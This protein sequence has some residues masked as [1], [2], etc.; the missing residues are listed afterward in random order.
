MIIRWISNNPLVIIMMAVIGP[1]ELSS[2][3]TMYTITIWML[4]HCQYNNT[5]GSKILLMTIRDD[6]EVA[7]IR[8]WEFNIHWIISLI[9]L[10]DLYQ[11]LNSLYNLKICRVLWSP[12]THQILLCLH[13]LFWLH[14]KLI[15]CMLCTHSHAVHNNFHTLGYVTYKMLWIS[16]SWG[17][18]TF[19][20]PAV[21][22]YIPVPWNCL[23]SILFWMKMCISIIW[24]SA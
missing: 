18:F 24:I 8:V 3:M 10:L 15:S 13:N 4:Y 17:V 22:S 9:L 5:L 16:V 14:V 2:I 12:I 19:I 1:A 11:K 21:L 23:F 6:Q 20:I 7:C